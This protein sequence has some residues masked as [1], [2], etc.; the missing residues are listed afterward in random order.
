M[1]IVKSLHS[2]VLT[3]SFSYKGRHFFALTALWAFR[4]DSGEPVLEK[5][6]WSEISKQLPPDQMLDAAMPKGCGEYLLAGR[7]F[8]PNNEPVQS[9]KVVAKVGE[10]EKTLIVHGDRFW[11]RF[12]HGESGIIGP[13]PITSISLDWKH[14]FG[15]EH[16]EPNPL[17]KGAHIIKLDEADVWPLPNVEYPNQLVTS[18]KSKPTPASFGPLSVAW[19]QRQ[20]R[21]G[22]YDEDYL[23]TRMPGF[24]D[25]IDWHFF[26]DAPDDQWCPQDTFWQDNVPFEFQYLNPEKPYLKG[27]VPA[28]IGRCF[29]LKQEADTQRFIELPTKVDTL[30]FFP[31][32]NL[33]IVMHRGSLEINTS[34]GTDIPK[35]LIAHE[36]KSDSPRSVAHYEFEMEKRTDPIEGHKY[37]LNTA[38]LIPEGCTCGFDV[39]KATNEFPLDMLA[40]K[41]QDRFA[42]LQRNQAMAS[43]TEQQTIAHAK[44][45]GA[46]VDVDAMLK[47][48]EALK[49]ESNPDAD[50]IHDLMN[51][52][53]PG[54]A[55]GQ[56][57]DFVRLDLKAVDELN[58]F[59]ADMAAKKRQQAMDD[60][61]K[62]IEQMKKMAV[63]PAALQSIEKFERRLLEL[64]LPPPLPRLDI[65]AQIADVQQQIQ[66]MRQDLAALPLNDATE[67]KIQRIQASMAQSESRFANMR[68]EIKDNYTKGAHLMSESRSPHA[69]EEAGLRLK[70]IAAIKQKQPLANGDFAFVDFSGLDLS[71]MDL[72]G[73][74]LEYAN[75]TNA[76]LKGANL[77]YAILAKSIL[78]NTNLQAADLTHANIGATQIENSCFDNA[79]MTQVVFGKACIKQSQFKNCVF[80]EELST[81]LEAK[82]EQCDFS[83]TVLV[84]QAFVDHDLSGCNF[85]AAD[86]SESS[87]VNPVLA[88][89]SFR[90][91]K[92]SAVNFVNARANGADFSSATLQN[93]RFVGKCQLEKAQF[94]KAVILMANLR[95][96]ELTQADFSEA[97]LDGSDC[98]GSNLTDA[99]MNNV[100]AVQTQFMKSN[101][102][103]ASLKH[104]KLFGASFMGAVLTGTDFS[105][106]NLHS[107]NFLSATLGNTQFADADLENTILRDWRP[108]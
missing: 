57:I 15:G 86:L 63:E 65:E 82:I 88:Q 39:I 61:A 69:G 84:K 10:L 16:Y 74:Y 77:Q 21:A 70:V 24:A 1:K 107:A 37:L 85:D 89:T 46:G 93:T 102:H 47:Q 14:A 19:P 11:N 51:K 26:N 79:K 83:N 36:N 54:F 97:R 96:C 73:C 75:F 44:L 68:R 8:S 92:L 105:E 106:S 25:D 59:I 87:F 32:T 108:N 58:A 22:T 100:S 23:K 48:W 72:S 29:V 71:G 62:Q 28:V 30:W 42:E 50:K 18:L 101:L 66:S 98:S 40:K 20:A 12:L 4:L 5:D 17:G 35:V 9:G 76:N 43:L 7:F 34:D 95:D 45:A 49:K 90:K 53:S 60:V 41:N 78:K 80:S 33:G 91:A 13:K 104:C 81:F 67:A 3:R 99:R 38:P 27:T 52:I 64:K 55:D 31:E 94:A 6:F 56:P 103:H 2:G